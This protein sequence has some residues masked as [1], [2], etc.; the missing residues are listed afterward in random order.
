MQSSSV[1]C[2]TRR[3]LAALAA[4]LR[5]GCLRLMLPSARILCFCFGARVCARNLQAIQEHL[6]VSVC[7]LRPTSSR[8]PH[9]ASQHLQ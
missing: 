3:C 6:S 7:V 2:R 9:I 1:T 5:S 8:N 4:R